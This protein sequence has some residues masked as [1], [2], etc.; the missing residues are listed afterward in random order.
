M[1]YEIVMAERMAISATRRR[2][3]ARVREIVLETIADRPV[4]VYLFGSH[5][6]GHVRPTSDIDVALEPLCDLAFGVFAE[7]R[8]RLEES[9]IPYDVDIVDLRDASIDLRERVRQE[10]I[11]WKG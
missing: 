9:T 11:V 6:T 10:G 2:A 7:L 4:R 1:C 8:E 3:L 5:A